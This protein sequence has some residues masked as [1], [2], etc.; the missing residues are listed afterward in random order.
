MFKAVNAARCALVREPLS[1]SLGVRFRR[2]SAGRGWSGPPSA[3]TVRRV[4]KVCLTPV[5]GA[6]AL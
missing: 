5:I 1:G 2:G 4:T 6:L 3:A